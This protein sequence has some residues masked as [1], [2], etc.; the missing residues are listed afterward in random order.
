MS[1]RLALAAAAAFAA[2]AV[3]AT[4]AA[5]ATLVAATPAPQTQVDRAPATVRLG[6]DQS[7]TIGSAPIRVLAADGT[8]LDGAPQ[9][10]DRGRTVGVPVTG[11]A[12]LEAYT[13]RWQAV[14]ADGHT[15]SG[16]YTFGIGIEPPPPTEAVGAV[17][18]T[19]RDKLVRWVLFVALALSVGVIGFRLLVLPP[20]VPP[21]VDRRVNAVSTVAAF[22]AID[23]GVV[24]LILRGQDALQLSFVDLL[25]GDLS[26]LAEKTRFGTA[27]MVTTVG[28]ALLAALLVVAWTLDRPALRRPAFVLGLLLLAAFPLS[29]HQ[30]TVPGSGFIERFADWAHLIAAMLWVGGLVALAAIVWPLA[31]EL[32]R[33]A[34]ARFSRVAT[35]CVAVI[36][37]GG[38]YLAIQRLPALSDVWETGYGRVLLIKSALVCIALAWGAGHRF[39]VL[40]RLRSGGEAGGGIARS[41][42]CESSVVMAVLLLAAILV[43]TSPPLPPG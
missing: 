35:V 37:I 22:A 34:F 11:L 8:R 15:I 16:V 6:F 19:W 41:L 12:D 43:N 21:A 4:A 2:V 32:R 7:V 3:P 10:L 13:V 29:G 5:H 1:R 27:W 36:V 14:S 25:Y 42:L 24:G 39:L 33:A 38:V 30:A 9:V 28:L 18:P 17:G 26:P 23:A 20:N 40:P 31:P